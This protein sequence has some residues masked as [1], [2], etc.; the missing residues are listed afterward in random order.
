LSPQTIVSEILL[1]KIEGLCNVAI[2]SSKDKPA[3]DDMHEFL[4]FQ[5][6]LLLHFLMVNLN[7]VKLFLIK[8]KTPI[9]QSFVLL[10][11]LVI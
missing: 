6:V 1:P 7:K 4:Y 9:K 2:I 10:V 5:T 3:K 11:F 8:L